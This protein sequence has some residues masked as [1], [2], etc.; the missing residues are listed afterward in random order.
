MFHNFL[1][2]SSKV[3]DFVFLFFS[4]HS[5]IILFPS[6]K[7]NIIARLEIELA[8]HVVAVQHFIHYAAVTPHFRVFNFERIIISLLHFLV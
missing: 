4:F 2:F 1:S 6:S 3:Q 8:Y 5:V 7:V